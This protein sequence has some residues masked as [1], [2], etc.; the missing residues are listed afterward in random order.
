MMPAA[1]SGQRMG[2]G[3]NKL[4]LILGNKPILIR[5]LEVFENDPACIGVFLAVK[6]E[7][8]S[9]IQAVLD[10]YGITKVSRFVDGG[11]ERQY[12]VTACVEAYDGNDIV[13]VHD[14]ARPFLHQSVINELVS[15]AA[16]SGAAIAGVQ[17]KD[18]MKLAPF[19]IVEETVD[20]ET[21]WIIQTPQAF[22]MDVLRKASNQAKEDGFL[23]TDE[24]MLV[25]RLG[26]PVKIVQST[27]DNVKMTTQED[28]V[29]GEIL[30]ERQRESKLKEE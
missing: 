28:I 16:K 10:Q 26:Y 19:G 2:A 14:A 8:Q 18:T 24:S 7:E 5:T 6:R 17:A 15:T 27:Y 12:S 9:E 13:L 21:L 20:R 11:S 25:E 29:F 1:G 3:Y 22:Q 4:F 23:G 30:L